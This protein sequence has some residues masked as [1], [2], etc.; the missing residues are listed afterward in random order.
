MQQRASLA[1]ERNCVNLM[2]GKVENG[3]QKVI[4]KGS[5]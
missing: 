4:R 1:S 5:K 2:A 3:E